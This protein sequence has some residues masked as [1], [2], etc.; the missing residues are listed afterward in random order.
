MNLLSHIR[1]ETEDT[2]EGP[3]TMLTTS[4]QLRQL[5]VFVIAFVLFLASTLFGSSALADTLRPCVDTGSTNGGG[6]SAVVT[7]EI[8]D[9]RGALTAF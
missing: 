9:S 3:S 6:G 7:E 2:T 1:I 5:R 4:K 8:V